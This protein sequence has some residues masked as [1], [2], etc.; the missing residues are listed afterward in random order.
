MKKQAYNVG[1]LRLPEAPRPIFFTKKSLTPRG[2]FKQAGTP[3]A[4]A[5]IPSSK[6]TCLS[7]FNGRK[8][9]SVHATQ[10]CPEQNR[11]DLTRG[12]HRQCA[13]FTDAMAMFFCN[14]YLFVL[15]AIIA[16]ASRSLLE[17]SPGSVCPLHLAPSEQTRIEPKILGWQPAHRGPISRPIFW[18]IFSE[19]MSRAIL[20]FLGPKKSAQKSDRFG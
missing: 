20:A 9:K 4:R 3:D 14:D 10:T 19:G 1:P 11:K 7:A 17:T 12:T 8:N 2:F 18:P 15:C 13:N 6:A 5:C 16:G